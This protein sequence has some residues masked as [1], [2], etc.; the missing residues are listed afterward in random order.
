MQ[1]SFGILHVNGTFGAIHMQESR[2]SVPYSGF[3]RC[4]HASCILQLA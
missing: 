3:C 1:D 2:D 4:M